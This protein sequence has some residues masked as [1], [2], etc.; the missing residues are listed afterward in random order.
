MAYS[1]YGLPGNE[2][3]QSLATSESPFPAEISEPPNNA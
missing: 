2:P 1:E 3:V